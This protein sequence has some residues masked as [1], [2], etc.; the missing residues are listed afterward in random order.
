VENLGY[1]VGFLIVILARQQLFTEITLTA[2]LP[3][4]AA[5]S[6]PKLRALGRLWSVVFAANMVGTALFAWASVSGL[7]FSEELR[8]GMLSVARELAELTFGQAFW[9]GIVA[10]WMIAT[11]VWVLPSAEVARLGVIVVITYLIALFEL[12]HVVAGSMEVFMLV[13]QGELGLGQGVLGFILPMLVGN[14]VGGSA[15]FALLAHGQV[16]DEMEPD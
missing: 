13:F 2:V 3:V 7:F 16:R 12:A 14:V 4:L 8:T 5:P 6:W 11:L 9:R 15:L 1:S 10:G